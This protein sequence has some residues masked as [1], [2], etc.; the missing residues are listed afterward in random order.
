M[1]KFIIW[2]RINW[3]KILLLTLFVS[4]VA[5]LALYTFYVASN[6][7]SLENF[8]KRQY[9]GQ[10]AMTM[11]MFIFA[12]L[13]VLPASFAMMWY[14]YKGG[15]IGGIKKNK[16]GKDGLEVRWD[17]IV[18]MTEAKND[19]MEVVRLLK[20]HA[21]QKAVGGNIIKGALMIG[22]PGCGKTYLAKAMATEC[23]LPMLT[24]S[25]SDFVAMFMGQ[26]AARMK[27]LFKQARAE[28]KVHGGCIVFIDEID[29]FAR[30]RASREDLP[31]ISGADIS[32]N[33]TINQF[34]TDFDGLRKKEN[35][36]IVLAATNVNEEELDEAIMRS[37]RFD[38]KIRV[39]KPNAADRAEVFKYYL[40]KVSHD[41]DLDLARLADRAKWFS[42]SDIN[43]VVKEAGVF[44][45][46]G[47]RD[48]INAEDMH[49]A[50]DRIMVS[51][52]KMGGD[53]ILG[54]KVN[55]FWDD[56]IGMKDVKE[57]AWEIV[58][59]LK[60]RNMAKAV[61]GKIVKGLVMFGPPGC[62]K[63]Y[64]AKA[65][66][67]ESGF[68]FIS[69]P[70]SEFVTMWMGEGV[71]KMKNVFSEARKM[72]KAEGGCIIFFDEID[73]FARHR[74]QEHGF[75]GSE[76]HNAT[77]NQFLT[78]LDGLRKQ[79]NTIMVL[80]ATNVREGDLDAAVTRAGRL[81][82]KLYVALPTLEER[83]ELFTFYFKKVKTAD[84][85]SPDR[86][87]RIAVG[88]SPSD[89][90]NIVR[91]A[92][93]LALRGSRDTICHKDLMEAYDRITIGAVSQDK[94]NKSSLLRTS[95]HESGH[96]LMTYLVHPTNEI[97]K[98]T[99]KPRKGALGYIWN[100]PVEEL[101]VSSPNREHCLSEIQV[102]LAGYVAEK[103]ALGTTA[104][105]VGGG[106]GSD[107]HRATSIA[108]LMV[109]SLGM[110]ES[111]LIGD[112]SAVGN[113]QIAQKTLEVLNADAQKIL[114]DCL[115]NTTKILSEHK[116]VLEYFAQE[117]LE[118]GDLEYNEVQA[119]FTKFRLK[120]A[121]GNQSPSPLDKPG[122]EA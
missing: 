11:P 4:V 63:T 105:G 119:I 20:D 80:G 13:L 52:E 61:G 6:F 10:M 68:P 33:A 49:N 46:R 26:G 40:S 89:I 29:A 25:G 79:E 57:D 102:L 90:D 17:D 28:A 23:G 73:S 86:W 101:A 113:D 9:A 55:V 65:I 120:S 43:N 58:K 88:V 118:K 91:E 83:K 112:F 37:G 92:G 53:R 3:I 32:H 117:L 108:H 77:I 116:D 64:L 85:V 82:R 103:I 35:N 39:E 75:G 76:N 94:Y 115:Q 19:A 7:N 8:T 93:L 97:I 16:I 111:G 30:K 5:F 106:P 72:A 38:R 100:R 84:D 110:G 21:L 48:R 14:F 99:I 74:V 96:A 81:E 27:S 54:D 66:A 60:D 71:K 44:A 31:A 18:G 104:S 36:I 122:P 121:T 2:L 12:Q 98:A 78:E 51:I 15:G 34:L 41:P 42:P 107:F 22:P 109:W 45:A 50:V 95:Y 70:G 87:A 24:A 56:V 62:G 67:T 69:M 1:R 114:Q 47:K 59:L